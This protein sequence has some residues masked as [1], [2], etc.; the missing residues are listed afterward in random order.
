MR[1]LAF[2]LALAPLF[3]PLA[4]LALFFVP[5]VRRL[6]LWG[7]ALLALY[8]ASLLLPALFAP[9]PL[10]WP[11]ALF[12]FLYVLGLVG[13]G[14]A[15]G[16]PERAL[17]A[18][19]VG[20]FLLYLTGFAATYWVLGDGAVGAR[21]SHPF[22]SPVGFGFLGGLGLL[23]AL[24]L[25]YPWPFR[26]LLGLLGGAVLLLSGSRG[27]MLG[28]FVGGAAAL[29]FRR[30]GLLA[31]ALG[32]GLLL[33]AFALNLP[34]TERFFQAHLSG[35]EGVWLAAYRV[36][37]EHP[38]TGVGPYLL[39]ERIGGVLFGDCF[40]FP[41][42]EARGLTCPDW[43]RPWGGLWTFAHNHLLQALGEGGV[44]GAVGLL[45]LAGGFLAGAWGDGLLF[46]L[47]AA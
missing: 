47:L 11:L 22:H 26:A 9:E 30:R 21:L 10:A 24:H 8:G 4:G 27:G 12:R 14:V 35:R 42:L 2:L 13:L 37:Q 28:F 16:R 7:Q 3:P 23:L 33:A 41:L 6:P 43:L 36:F 40:L 18:W 31:L 45:L 1:G 46:G 44:F 25:R 38:W 15:L 39:G 19:G 34:A 20:L 29:L 5:W 32:G 17:G